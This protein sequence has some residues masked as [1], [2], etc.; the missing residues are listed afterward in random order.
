LHY[1][2]IIQ[3]TKMPLLDIVMQLEK[4]DFDPGGLLA[5]VGGVASGGSSGFVQLRHT[6]PRVNEPRQEQ[7]SL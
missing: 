5:L 2:L 7:K 6:F 4:T 1:G 3:I